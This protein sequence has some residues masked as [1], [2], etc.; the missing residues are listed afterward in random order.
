MSNNSLKLVNDL[1]QS[2]ECGYITQSSLSGSRVAQLLE[3]LEPFQDSF[4]QQHGASIPAAYSAKWP[5]DKL[6]WWSRPQEY[7]FVL[8]HVLS[9]LNERKEGLKILEFGPGC[10]FV[11]H[12]LAT[13][14]G[15][16]K[17]HIEE[18]DDDV[19][20]FW[21]N[22]GPEFDFKIERSCSSR[23]NNKAFDIIY[24]VSVV[25]HVESPVE[26]IRGLVKQLA[27]AGKLVLTLD[28]D[29]SN[30]GR[31]GL[32]VDQLSGILQMEEIDFE[33]LSIFAG[34]P[35]LHDVATPK[36]GWRISPL[37]SP[38]GPQRIPSARS[39]LSRLKDIGKN[40]RKSSLD[41]SNICVIKLIGQK[42]IN[43]L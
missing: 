5:V 8:F 6:H 32:T 1:L 14:A 27:S 15:L 10:S 16:K 22:I 3:I 25:E 21:E 39:G 2:R 31:Y 19:V 4:L 9:A 40:F 17:L 37:G 33:P 43:C 34:C 18:I 29:L 20:R 38:G 13:I 28:V 23:E 30:F 26:A 36:E 35:H 11:P 24:S 12:V 7:G 41:S 42:N